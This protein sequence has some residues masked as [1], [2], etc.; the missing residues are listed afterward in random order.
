MLPMKESHSKLLVLLES[1]I[2][3]APLSLLTGWY[4]IILVGLYQDGL[5]DEPV[6]AQI[7]PA[8]AFAGLILQ[9]LA[10]RV[11]FVFLLHGRA[12]IAKLHRVVVLMMYIGAV[13]AIVGG[14][15]LLLS[16]VFEGSPILSF[17][18]INA[19][20]LPAIVPFAHIAVEHRRAA[21]NI[22]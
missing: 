5:A 21:S 6:S 2:F 20:G 17:L 15:S 22:S 11:V 8:F 3:L 14:L 13:L 19:L 1:V 16:F 9:A 7:V 4:V 10:W 12:G 18:A